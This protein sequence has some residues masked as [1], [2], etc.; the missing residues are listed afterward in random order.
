M[1]FEERLQMIRERIEAI[2]AEHVLGEPLDAYFSKGA[3]FLKLIFEVYDKSCA[4]VISEMTMDELK[5]L[6]NSLYSDILPENYEVSFTNPDYITHVFDESGIPEGYARAL[7]FLFAKLRVLIGYAFEKRED[8]ITLYAELFLQIYTMF[9]YAAGEVDAAE[10]DEGRLVGVPECENVERAISSFIHDNCEYFTQQSIERRVN[11]EH[12]WAVRL[13]MNSELNDLRYLYRFGEYISDDVIKVASFL[14]TLDEERIISMARTYTEGYRIGF[15]KAG[16]PLEKKRTVYIYYRL[17]FE[18]IVREAIK[19]FAAMNLKPT[20]VRAGNSLMMSAISRAGFMGDVANRQ[21]EFDHKEDA[22][23]FLDKDYVKKN[24]E[25]TLKAY[26][27]RQQ[28]ANEVAGPACMEVFGETP[29]TPKSKDS[30]LNYSKSQQELLVEM[31][32][33][34]GEIT[35]EYIIGEERSFTIIAYPMPTIGPDFEKIFEE[36]VKLNTLDY[37]KYEAIQQRMIDALNPADYVHVVGMNGNIT[38]VIVRLQKVNNPDKEDNFENCVADVNIPVGEVFTSPRL[39]GT[40]GILH[41]SGVYLEGLFYKDLKITFKDGMIV[42]YSCANYDT[43]SKNRKFI[44]D[45]LLFHHDTLPLGE[46]AIG[47]NTTAYKMARDYRIEALMP[48]LIGEK[49]GPHFAV[50]DTCYSHEEDVKVYNANGHEIIARDNEVSKLRNTDS[51]RAYFNCHTD[52]TIPYDELG[53]IEAVGSADSCGG[54]DYR[55]V[56]IENGR[57]VLEGTKDLNEPL[58]K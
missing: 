26:K 27:E 12:D 24:V 56:I 49:T 1:E 33:K 38:D 57:F 19:Q 14:N 36:T 35:N 6:N 44:K 7:C 4:D 9:V 45:N 40:N 8:A 53:L 32:G 18:R 5:E 48:I 39:S 58:E 43:P 11:P 20:I 41:V 15:V 37:K 31:M 23:L 50:G 34:L 42:D 52:I 25:Y 16:K 10:A 46:F 29:F 13:I 30:A 2:S 51:S 22:A 47:T 55:A 54:E 3:E 21:Y 28:L 17:G